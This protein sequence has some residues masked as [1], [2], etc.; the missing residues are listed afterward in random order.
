MSDVKDD[1]H[2]GAVPAEL[3]ANEDGRLAALRS[4]GLLDSL[5]EDV[6]DD[7]VFLASTICET[8]IALIS[9]VD[10][11]RQFFKANVGLPVRETPRE[12][13]FC[14]HA[15]LGDDLFVVDDAT[16]DPRFARNPLVTGAPD[17]RFYAGVPLTDP[18]GHALGTLCAIDT[19][20]R[21]LTA[22]QQRALRVLGRQ[23]MVQLEL[24]RA[25]LELETSLATREASPPGVPAD[26]RATA[27]RA[28]RILEQTGPE[29]PM[30]D[31]I[32]EL[33]A[34]LE[35]MQPALRKP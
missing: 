10:E 2:G 25:I 6:Y 17:I 32:R 34:R 21:E 26:L 27:E 16:K 20:P 18:D 7:L 33:L 3:P 8:P 35:R 29:N 9:L 23:V 22:M 12:L 31:R 30:Q 15:I 5:P 19:K 4:Y 13:A 14:A 11:R 1:G 28:R 24:R